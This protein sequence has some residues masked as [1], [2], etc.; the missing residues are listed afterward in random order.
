MAN[1]SIF[2][3]Q[4]RP[5]RKKYKTFDRELIALYFVICHCRYFLESRELNESTDHKPITFCM[6]KISDPW[7]NQQQ[8]HLAYIY[9]FTTNKKDNKI[10]MFMFVFLSF[11]VGQ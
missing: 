3:E 10:E 1:T 6:Y 5:W 2:S 4:L 11:W 9:E 7:T 8:Q